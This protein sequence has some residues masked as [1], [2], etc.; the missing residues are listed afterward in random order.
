MITKTG[1]SLQTMVFSQMAA[2]TH[3]STDDKINFILTQVDPSKFAVVE[4]IK[5]F[6]VIYTG[7]LLYA[8]DQEPPAPIF[9]KMDSIMRAVQQ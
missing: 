1:M 8:R 7:D 4:T 2:K 9:K 6:L 5:A 3:S